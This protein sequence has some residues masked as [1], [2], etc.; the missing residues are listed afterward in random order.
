MVA[1]VDSRPSD[2]MLL[3][4]APRGCLERAA[5][6]AEST[7]DARFSAVIDSGPTDDAISATGM[8]DAG[9]L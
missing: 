5:I 2:T 9:F 1:M 4:K 8:L 6:D 3:S 7:D